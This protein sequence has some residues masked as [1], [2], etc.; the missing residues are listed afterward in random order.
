MEENNLYAPVVIPTLCR[1]KHL[2]KC[3][4]SLMNCTHANKT[5]VYIGLDYPLNTS[6]VEGYNKILQYL[7]QL[8]ETH[9]FN[10]LNIIRRN[11]NYG[12]GRNGNIDSLINAVLENHES[13]IFS[14]DD[15]IFAP[16]FLDYINKGLN[17][18]INDK[19]ILAICGYRHYY[20]VRY[21]DNNIYRQNIDF[22]AWGYGMWKDRWQILNKLD[23]DWFKNKFS[24]KSL[25]NL[26][27]HHGNNRLLDYFGL[28]KAHNIRLTDNTFSIYM[29][30]VGTN[31]VMPTISLVRN[32]GWDGSGENCKTTDCKMI[33]NHQNNKLYEL[34]EYEIKGSGLEYYEY[35]NRIYIKQSYARISNVKMMKLLFHKIKK[36]LRL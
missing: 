31:I 26:K 36:R 20:D 29:A 17:L 8:E 14:E 3:L 4:E 28:L 19:S 2:K 9:S 5:D 13:F 35:N 33:S 30:L 1:F 27:F 6:H 16:A 10:S 34:M 24:I 21:E 25:W 7:N 18:F 12:L 23:W 32:C 11:K 22:S 15:N